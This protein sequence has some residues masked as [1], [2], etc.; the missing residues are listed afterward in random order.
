[1]NS[2]AAPLLRRIVY[3]CYYHSNMHWLNA[4]Q[5]MND[6]IVMRP[7][8]YPMVCVCW[9]C[10]SG[11][12]HRKIQPIHSFSVQQS[13]DP[14]TSLW[15][16]RSLA[17]SY[18]KML[19]K[20]KCG[21]L[22][23]PSFCWITNVPIDIPTENRSNGLEGV[24]ETALVIGSFPGKSQSH[25]CNLLFEIMNIHC[26]WHG[27]VWNWQLRCGNVSAFQKSQP[28]TILTRHVMRCPDV[29]FNGV[30]ISS[31]P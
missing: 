13:T 4:W 22:F 9:D 24:P 23:L 26:I 25:I 31:V 10:C 14:R 5:W 8:D 12:S 27:H 6:V 17:A 19:S 11:R 15:T 29:P 16:I 28:S 30:E 21:K 20:C 7:T 3:I 1:M 2:F 18:R